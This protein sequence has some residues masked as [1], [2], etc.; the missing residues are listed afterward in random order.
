ML[1]LSAAFGCGATKGAV[2]IHTLAASAV[3]DTTSSKAL[4]YA[5]RHAGAAA[6]GR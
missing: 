2:F 6:R 5:T 3:E 4:R 1:H